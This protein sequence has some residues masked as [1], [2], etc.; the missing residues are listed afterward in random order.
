MFELRHLV[1]SAFVVD[2]TSAFLRTSRGL[3][4]AAVTAKQKGA[5]DSRAASEEPL[6]VYGVPRACAGRSLHYHRI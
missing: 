4:C 3:F 5:G 6:G 2:L 1:F